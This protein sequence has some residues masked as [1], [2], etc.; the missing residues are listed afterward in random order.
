MDAMDPIAAA[1][2]R[3]GV[4]TRAQLLA[5]GVTAARIRHLLRQGLLERRFPGVY[6]VAGAPRS[7][8]QR[9][10]AALERAGPGTHASHRCAAALW[11]LRR[12]RRPQLELT[13][14]RNRLPRL[15]DDAVVHRSVQL[16][17]LHVIERDDGIRLTPPAVTLLDVAWVVDDD[18]L[19]HAFEDAVH[20]RLTTVEEV[21]AT[22]AQLGGIG[23]PGTARLGRLLRARRRG[24]A[25]SG[26]GKELALVQALRRV[27]APP[28]ARQHP[29]DL[30]DG[31]R[32]H[33]DL[34]WP[35]HRLAVEVDG[36]LWHATREAQAAD[37]DRDLQMALIGWR[38]QRLSAEQA[39]QHA[40]ATAQALLALLVAVE[41]RV[42]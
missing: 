41:E 1:R 16:D 26:S 19:G 12:I 25:V 29:L 30:L 24:D 17:R 33:V 11:G 2:H 6:A 18:T 13:V 4:V 31:R 32:I 39:E 34:A 35:E 9:V 5:G 22:L 15:G 38:C 27:G 37:H 21:E 36:L 14:A 8:E 28:P 3:H 10:L 7:F 42:A 40:D 23:R 20:R